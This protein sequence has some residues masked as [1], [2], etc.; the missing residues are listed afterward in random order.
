MSGTEATL[1]ALRFAR[2][3]TGR[4]RRS[5]K[6][7]GHFHGWH[8][9]VVAAVNPP[10][11]VP[12]S[13]GVPDG[14]A[15]PAPRCARPTTSRRSE[16]MLERGDVAA[17]ILEPTGGHSGTTP[18]DP[19]L[20]PGAARA[21]PRGTSVV[22]IFDEVITGFRYCAGRRAGL[23]RRDPGHDHAGE[24]RGRRPARR[25]RRRQEASCMSMMAHRGDPVLDR[26]QRVAQNGTFNS[27]P[28]CAAAAIATLELVA[29]GSLHARANK[30]G[31]ELRAG[32][33]G[34]DEARWACPAP[35]SARRR[36]ST[37]RS[38]ASPAWPVSTAR[39]AATSTSGCAAR[40]STTAWTAPAH[41]GWISAV[42]TR[43]RHRAH[44]RGPREG[45]SAS[46]AADGVFKGM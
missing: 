4:G 10:Y 43:C 26:S 18:T 39:A 22:L 3:F 31:D 29:D 11:D 37:C 27:N 15:R 44:R 2:A 7:Q 40:C 9:G 5:L 14:G 1:L 13:A 28:V 38:R 19:R 45:A 12:M 36:S 16:T 20:P 30:L 8:D 6:F 25:R 34:G 33:V 24:D 46:M 42:H 17:V 41:H 32:P 21:S 23:L 35:A